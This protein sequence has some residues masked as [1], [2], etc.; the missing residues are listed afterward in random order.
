MPSAWLSN[1][2]WSAR[3]SVRGISRLLAV[4]GGS[5]CCRIPRRL[6]TASPPALPNG[7]FWGGIAVGFVL[8]HPAGG[9]RPDLDQIG[10]AR[11]NPVARNSP[12]IASTSATWRN[13]NCCVAWRKSANWR[14]RRCSSSRNSTE[15]EKYASLAQLALGAAHE[16][17]N[18]LL[19]IL[20]H[21]ELEWKDARRR[22]P[23]RDRAVHRRRQAN[24]FGGARIA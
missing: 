1:R 22:T 19:G 17:N 12:T 23:G 20:S 4:A 10:R 9:L 2:L 24:F 11:S 14:K 16:I 7:G 15:Y 5:P 8:L 13:R 6:P 3:R 21:L 18:P